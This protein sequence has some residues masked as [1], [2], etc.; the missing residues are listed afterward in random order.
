MIESSDPL[1]EETAN[2][3]P[4][5]AQEDVV[6]EHPPTT[7]NDEVI[8]SS[9]PPSEETAND[10]PVEA[11]EDVV[12]E[13]PPTTTN[14][15]VIESSDPP[16]EETANDQPVEAQEDV[17]SDE[18]RRMALKKREP[19]STEDAAGSPKKRAKVYITPEER[20][21][22]PLSQAENDDP[23][24]Y[25]KFYSSEGW[26]WYVTAY[27]GADMLYGYVKGTLEEWGRFTISELVKLGNVE[28][29]ISFKPQKFS[30]LKNDDLKDVRHT[31]Y[32]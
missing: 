16:S 8:E 15:E 10:Q 23:M 30:A 18:E 3:Q 19:P 25:V 13:H 28:R 17:E 7:T 22:I 12:V 6:V 31:I 1:S 9:D 21:V 26:E 32:A 2:D 4:V 5:D 14:A 27:N 24:I 20:T 11:Q 29:D